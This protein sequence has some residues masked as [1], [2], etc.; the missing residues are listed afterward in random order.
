M[1]LCL[2]IVWKIN[3]FL[4]TLTSALRKLI[5]FLNNRAFQSLILIMCVEIFFVVNT[6]FF[7]IY[8]IAEK[9]DHTSMDNLLICYTVLWLILHFGKLILIIR[10]N[11]IVQDEKTKTGTI[12]YRFDAL[13]AFDRQIYNEVIYFSR[14]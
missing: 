12:I 10:P 7:T 4:Y 3:L 9:T 2:V 5:N 8:K 6:Q 13:N 14:F 11:A 1:K